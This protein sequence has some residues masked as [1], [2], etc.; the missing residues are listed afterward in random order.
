[1]TDAEREFVPGGRAANRESTRADR[2]EFKARKAEHESVRG[3]AKRARRSI[4][5]DT[6]GKVLES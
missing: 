3:R 5:L 2:R 1:V 4:E 6:A